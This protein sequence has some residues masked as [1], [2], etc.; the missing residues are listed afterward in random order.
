MGDPET[1]AVLPL[2]KTDLMDIVDACIDGTLDKLNVEWENKTGFTV[3]IASGGYPEKV[4]KG[5]EITIGELSGVTLY[6]AG[7]AIKDGVLVTSGGRVF[8]LS[9]VGSD[10]E[11]A[12]KLVYGQIDKIKFT[13]CRYR[14]DIGKV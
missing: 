14:S 4:V 1:E 3:V 10:L 12:K 6:H 5:Y 8:E 13:D 11:S 9:G 2:L 7:T